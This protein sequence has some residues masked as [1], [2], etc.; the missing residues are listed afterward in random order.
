MAL[1]CFNFRITICNFNLITIVIIQMRKNVK[2]ARMKMSVKMTTTT[3]RDDP[4]E[5]EGVEGE[6]GEHRQLHHPEV[7]RLLLHEEAG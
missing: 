4:D 7:A 5:E 2:K 3:D 6:D 1:R